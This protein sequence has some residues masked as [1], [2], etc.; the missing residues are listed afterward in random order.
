M[1]FDMTTAPGAMTGARY[2][3]SLN[4][5]REVWVYHAR[6]KSSGQRYTSFTNHVDGK[7]QN[8]EVAR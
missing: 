1:G 5:G 4:D 3:S 7:L 2:I 8:W 6:S